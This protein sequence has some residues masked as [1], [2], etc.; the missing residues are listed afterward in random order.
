MYERL[1]SCHTKAP[2]QD[3]LEAVCKDKEHIFNVYFP[4]LVGK[5]AEAMKLFDTNDDQKIEFDEFVAGAETLFA[6]KAPKMHALA[7]RSKGLTDL[8]AALKGFLK[9][10][11]AQKK[12]EEAVAE[13]KAEVSNEEATKAAELIDNEMMTGEKED[14]AVDIEAIKA[15][16]GEP[17]KPKGGMFGPSQAALDKHKAAMEAAK[18]EIAGLSLATKQRRPFL[19]NRAHISVLAL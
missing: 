10:E 18:A 8:D 13:I 12:A 11:A 3:E 7:S 17:E 15:E 4:G 1:K 5:M 2:I 16:V 14:D 19:R 6:Q 9:D